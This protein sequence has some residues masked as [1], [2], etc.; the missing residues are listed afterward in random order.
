M[1][2]PRVI[3]QFVTDHLWTLDELDVAMPKLVDAK[4]KHDAEVDSHAIA[5][6]L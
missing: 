1:Q 5:L 6:T 3:N 2:Q 4:H